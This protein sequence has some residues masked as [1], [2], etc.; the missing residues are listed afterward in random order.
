[1]IDIN[2][3]DKIDTNLIL[4]SIQDNLMEIERDKW[5]NILNEQTFKT[6]NNNMRVLKEVLLEL[7]NETNIT[8]LER[9]KLRL[10]NLETDRDSI[11]SIVD[12]NTNGL[13][14]VGITE[15]KL[16]LKGT[17]LEFNNNEINLDD[18]AFKSK[19]NTFK[20]AVNTEEHF[21]IEGEKIIDIGNSNVNV[22]N[23]KNL[24]NLISSEDKILLNGVEFKQIDVATETKAG[25]ITEARIKEIAPKPDLTNYYTKIETDSKSIDVATETKAGIITEAR[26]KEI[27][28]QP[29]L[30]PYVTFTKGFRNQNNA[31]W[32]VRT[33]GRVTWGGDTFEMWN[34]DNNQFMG[35][36]HTNSYNS[37][38]KVPNRNGGNWNRILD[39]H[40]YNNLDT[41]VN[42]IV[43][44]Y[45]RDLRL[46]GYISVTHMNQGSIERY[47]YVVT[48]LFNADAGTFSTGDLVQMRA[49]QMNR[50]GN[51]Y[52]V[53]FA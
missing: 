33:N 38:Y 21:S 13:I 28:P 5:G 43:G 27:A 9:I 37:F 2:K 16:N 51:W 12:N 10:N 24:I 7:V 23:P 39:E 14:N 41:P 17:Q 6:L 11:E 26:I 32:F 31:D 36:F 1:M 53:P 15:R 40:D 49:L 29:D 8:D 50:G 18:I 3:I 42:Q 46:S 4:P 34:G 30:T 25:I 45:V 22:G 44:S 35:A 52:N 20:K 48:G 47:G 19:N